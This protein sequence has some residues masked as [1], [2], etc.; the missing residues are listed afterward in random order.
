MHSRD[1]RYGVSE[2]NYTPQLSSVLC[3]SAKFYLFLQ[4]FIGIHV[5]CDL[6][7]KKNVLLLIDSKG[8]R[9]F[10]LMLSVSSLP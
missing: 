6:T 4:D 7:C 8:K 3:V 10:V 9:D 2:N 1:N 5:S